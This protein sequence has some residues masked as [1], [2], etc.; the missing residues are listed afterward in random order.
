MTGDETGAS[1]RAAALRS[2][3]DRLASAGIA[4]AE[5]EAD[6][7]TLLRHAAGLVP[8]DLAA[9][10]DVPLTAAEAA[11]FE[12]LIAR[13]VTREPVGR[14]LGSRSFW[15]LNFTLSPDTLEPRDDSETVILKALALLGPR[16][17]KPLSIL[18]LGTGTGCLL[19]A[20]LHECPHAQGLGVDISEG[21]LATARAN[22]GANGVEGRCRWRQGNWA[23]GLDGSF[24]LII[25]N[26]PYIRTADMAALEPEVRAHDPSA[27]LHGGVD[28]LEAYRVIIAALPRLLAHEGMA[29]LEIGA[30]QGDAI[31]A[32][33]AAQGLMGHS[34][35]HDLGG[36]ERAIG[37]W[38]GV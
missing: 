7:R 19:V 14:I 15:G 4:P 18:D 33:A 25:S 2:A 24:D 32:L 35:R 37:L 22:A 6:A 28:G 8:I 31:R 21:A 10:G 36:H 27:A 38:R 1:T 30:G 20:L 17:A 5:A 26:P 29:V 16:R 13:R 23:T 3:R 12:A 9:R 11:R 34:A